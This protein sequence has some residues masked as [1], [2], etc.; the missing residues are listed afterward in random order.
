MSRWVWAGTAC[1]LAFT[2]PALA[3]QGAKAGSAGAQAVDAI[4]SPLSVL[5]L[6]SRDI[7][8]V[9]LRAQS[10]P[11]NLT[12]VPDCE[13]LRSEIARLERVL[14][15][16][17]DAEADK[18]GLLSKG[19]KV[20]GNM[21]SGM[22]PFGGLVR[23]F[24]GANARR[25]EWKSAVY[26]GVARRSYLKGYGKGLACVTATEQAVQTAEDVLRMPPQ[27]TD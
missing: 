18:A 25:A 24:S 14:G 16:D 1:L 5:N 13:T 27:K 4:T 19:L 6:R 10:Q 26:A 15:P 17:A 9:L 11:Y 21:L 20:G 23:Q 12:S 8:D 7:P 3:Q 22:I 2:A